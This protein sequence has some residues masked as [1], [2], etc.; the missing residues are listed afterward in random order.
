MRT[1]K[2]FRLV[3]AAVLAAGITTAAS[4]GQLFDNLFFFGDSLS[5]IGN[6]VGAPIVNPGGTLWSSNLAEKYGINLL[7]SSQ[8]GTDYAYAFAETGNYY[9]PPPFGPTPPVPPTAAQQVQAYLNSTGG[10]ADRNALYSI[11]AGSN[12]VN[13]EL[14]ARV[15]FFLT[16]GGTL[17]QVPA[18][19]ASQAPS[20]ITQI[21]NDITMLVANLHNAGAKYI[22][23]LNLPDL[24]ITPAGMN[25]PIF[26]SSLSPA[27]TSLSAGTN[28]LLTAELS[29]LGYHVIQLDVFSIFHYIVSH[30]GVFGFT[31]VTQ[32]Y[33][34]S[35]TTNPNAYLFWDFEHP[36]SA[37]QKIIS[38]YAYAT[39]EAPTFVGTMADAPFGV[40][41]AQNTSM[42]NQLFAVRDRIVNSPIGANS[43]IAD[44]NYTNIDPSGSGTESPG[45]DGSG[46]NYDVGL[47]HRFNCNFIAG[48]DIAKS[49]NDIDVG[50]HMGSY[51]LNENLA[52]L[53][54]SY[55]YGNFY[56]D[57]IVDG[58]VINYDN[59]ERTFALGI[60]N[61]TALSE[62]DGEQIG[63][64]LIL[65]YNIWNC[66][67]LITG[68]II[69]ADYQYVKVDPF[70]EDGAPPGT[71]LQFA[72][73][74]NQSFVTG[75]GWQ[76]AYRLDFCRFTLLPYAQAT[77]DN[78]W[79]NGD[80]RLVTASVLTLP[81]SNFAI[82]ILGPDRDFGV[83]SAGVF[84]NL[85]NNLTIG[86]AYNAVVESGGTTQNVNANLQVLI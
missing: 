77:Y 3:S 48:A 21:A 32:P 16:H 20:L 1:K 70:A 83:L 43:F 81:G 69:N 2:L 24:G 6:G 29:N 30:P 54:G 59:V 75:Y 40:F 82:P 35:G 62:T 37:G 38:D 68:P 25:L 61:Q 39:I 46:E 10:H 74:Y 34:T 55:T 27:L 36:T 42:E 13:D 26:G 22:M 51:N 28:Q 76:G 7:P 41:D 50:N 66:P 57:G 80:N 72:S 85:T 45:F 67:T 44:F 5:D 15:A 17:P 71:D 73:Q 19:I 52:S 23:V 9:P 53:F 47:M 79:I 12:N 18:F 31:N 8:G 56:A 11:W 78:Q 86:V 58:G 60:S 65:G 84:A 49:Y 33:Q 63:G 14:P 4:A 64:D